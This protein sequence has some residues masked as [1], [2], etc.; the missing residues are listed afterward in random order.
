MLVTVAVARYV[1]SRATPFQDLSHLIVLSKLIRTHLLNAAV[2]VITIAAVISV[3]LKLNDAIAARRLLQPQPPKTISD[4]R[5]YGI[6]GD[7]VGSATAPVTVVMFSDFQ[8]PY[9]RNADRDLAE[10]RSQQPGLF[11][12][13]YRHY[14]LSFHTFAHSAAVAAVCADRQ[15][16]FN[17]MHDLLFANRDSLSNK[18]WSEYGRLAKVRDLSLFNS[19]LSSPW[20]IARVRTDSLAGARLGVHGTPTFLI[21]NLRVTGYPGRDSILKFIRGAVPPRS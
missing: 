4:W 9:C 15:D 7:R 8:C 13:L 21:N 20:A 3:G 14:P 11:S 6:Q 1:P 2:A 12:I 19:C 10:I 16:A 18:S 5:S 17:A